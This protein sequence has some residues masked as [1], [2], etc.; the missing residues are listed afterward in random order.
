M[1]KNT[2]WQSNNPSIFQI[3]IIKILRFGG[4]ILIAFNSIFYGRY[5]PFT[6]SILA[7]NCN[8]M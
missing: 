5:N 7:E 3:E 1:D 2:N 8:A 4:E 6:L